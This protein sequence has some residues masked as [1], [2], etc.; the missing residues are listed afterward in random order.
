[1]QAVSPQAQEPYPVAQMT[2]GPP[3]PPAQSQAPPPQ[4]Q[5]Q[6]PQTRPVMEIGSNANRNRNP[7][8]KLFC[9]L[10]FV[11]F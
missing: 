10:N 1:M 5:A 8:G 2:Q 4:S 9:F 3:A 11:I 7:N 6:P